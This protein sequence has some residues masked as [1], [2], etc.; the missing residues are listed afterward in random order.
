M[1][2]N[3]FLLILLSILTIICVEIILYYKIESYSESPLLV[4]QTSVNMTPLYIKWLTFYDNP[5]KN[6][7]ADIKNI[8]FRDIDQVLPL[9]NLLT[10]IDSY[11][12]ARK[13]DNNKILTV[14]PARSSLIFIKPRGQI[15]DLHLQDIIYAN[16]IIAYKFEY[17]REL[18]E[19][20][21]L[22]LSID[23][24]LLKF[25]KLDFD[26]I[27]DDLFTTNDIDVL[28][29]FTPLTNPQLQDWFDPQFKIDFV[30]YE[31]VDINIIKYYF[32]PALLNNWSLNIY[33]PQYQVEFPVKQTLD[34][35][36]LLIGNKSLDNNLDLRSQLF[37][38]IIAADNYDVNNLYNMWFPLFSQT[39]Q[40]IETQ[41]SH[42]KTRDSLTILEQYSEYFEYSPNINVKGYYDSKKETLK[43]NSNLIQGVPLQKNWKVILQNQDRSEEN[44]EYFVKNDT[45]VLNKILVVHLKPDEFTITKNTLTPGDKITAVQHIPWDKINSN[46]KLWI[47]S[48]NRTGHKSGDDIILDVEPIGDDDGQWGCTDQTIKIKGLCI[49]KYDIDGNPKKKLTYWD[50]PCKSNDECPYYQANKN[51]PNYRGNC[52]NG[53]CELPIGMKA[54]AYR[55]YDPDFKPLCYGCHGINIGQCC[56]DQVNRDKYPE[57]NGPDYVFDLDSFERRSSGL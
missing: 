31:N 13:P 14:V 39:E 16:K 27:N 43:L 29:I 2:L 22:S 36:L 28:S 45:T 52:T 40:Y 25:Q 46:N 23:K 56:E 54:R 24:S 32:P 30:S 8:H 49:S 1:V 19:I 4:W 37:E 21:A 20:I 9:E 7:I 50:R 17:Q 10:L 15:I 51:Y 3:S 47:P 26:L 42:T 41:N 44:G 33:F 55:M 57:L 38:I 34:I 5:W 35:D 6:N 18:I 53:Y 11:S 48:I 12:F